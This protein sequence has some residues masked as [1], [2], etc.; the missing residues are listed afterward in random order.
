MAPLVKTGQSVLPRP[1]LSIGKLLMAW[2]V[3]QAT[4]ADL[5]RLDPHLLDDIGL[6]ARTRDAECD[7][8][9]WQD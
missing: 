9:F 7:K 1:F 2:Q 3:R 5:A 4:R 8:A 6:A